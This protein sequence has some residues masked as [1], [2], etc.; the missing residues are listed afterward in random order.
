MS[1]TPGE[2]L[3]F[4]LKSHDPQAGT[5]IRIHYPQ[6]VSRNIRINGKRVK[7]TKWDNK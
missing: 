6:S 7:N 2:K 3:R 4:M 1:G 5:T